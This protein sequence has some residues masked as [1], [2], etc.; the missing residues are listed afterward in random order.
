MVLDILQTTNTG[1]LISIASENW[2]YISKYCEIS[3][4]HEC[5]QILKVW[6]AQYW[7]DVHVSPVHAGLK[8]S[9][10]V[11][12]SANR[13]NVAMTVDIKL[14]TLLPATEVNYPRPR[15]PALVCSPGRGLTFKTSGGALSNS[16]TSTFQHLQLPGPGSR[17]VTAVT[18]PYAA[19]L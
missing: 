2:I 8:E 17:V 9:V 13:L 1:I 11:T 14:D 10:F 3:F 16:A 12:A 15:C 19:F 18:P 4:E 5:G 7:Q 6:T